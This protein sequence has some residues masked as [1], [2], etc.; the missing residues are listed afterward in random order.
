MAQE[1]L[2]IL[3][4]SNETW[5]LSSILYK[6]QLKMDQKHWYK[7]WNLE[8]AIG[9]P[10][11]NIQDIGVDSDFLDSTWVELQKLKK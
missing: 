3:R 8:T 2:D 4:Q 1:K 7:T 5:S 9:K 6:I 11:E 10:R